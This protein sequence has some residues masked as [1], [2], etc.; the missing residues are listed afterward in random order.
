[1]GITPTILWLLGPSLVRTVREGRGE[2]RLGEFNNT[3]LWEGRDEERREIRREEKRIKKVGKRIKVK[4]MGEQREK[5]KRRE[6]RRGEE[7]RHPSE[8]LL[9]FSHGLQV[10]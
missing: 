3:T 10:I 1:M 5:E 4:K 6:E 8:R 2:I 7:R 9:I